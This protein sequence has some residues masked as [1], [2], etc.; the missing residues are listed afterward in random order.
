MYKK[1][2]FVILLLGI[3]GSAFADVD[4]NN[5]GGD[6]RWDNAA[7]WWDNVTLT[8]HVPG[9]GD[10]VGIRQG[11][12]GPIIDSSTAALANQCVLSDWGS[13]GDAIDITGGS[14]TTGGWFILGYGATN[15]G[16]DNV[17]GGTPTV[18]GDMSVGFIGAGHM[19]MTNGTV[20][21]TGT[22]GIATNGGSG[23]VELDGGT[24]SCNAFSM[25]TGATMD[26]TGGS[27]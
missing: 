15:D 22:F 24:I 21:V 16:T 27:G 2:I 17:S 9:S 13:F 25:A 14:L 18:S 12:D 23:H 4:W 3:V 1:I 8:A 10:K 20:T 19:N 26:I 5:G 7:N 11:G 6:R